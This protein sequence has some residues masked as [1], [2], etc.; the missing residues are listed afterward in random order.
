MKT[1]TKYNHSFICDFCG[2]AGWANKRTKK[3]CSDNHRAAYH[4]VQKKL[5]IEKEY[6]EA[7]SNMYNYFP[8][9]DPE[10]WSRSHTLDTIKSYYLYDG[11]LPTTNSIITICKFDIRKHKNKQEYQVRPKRFRS[12]KK[13]EI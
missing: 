9:G 12:F 4:I 2:K 1:H 11:P 7:L 8:S 6:F 5:K 13:R 10:L 3:F